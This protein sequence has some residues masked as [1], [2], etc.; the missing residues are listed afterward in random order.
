MALQKSYMTVPKAQLIRENVLKAARK[1]GIQGD[2]G[3]SKIDVIEA[4]LCL[5][6]IDSPEAAEAR[7]SLVVYKEELT[8]AKQQIAGYKTGSSKLKNQVAALK[9]ELALQKEQT[10]EFRQKAERY[11]A[12]IEQEANE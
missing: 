10:E 8:K 11:H 3:Y 6:T 4:W 1:W 9:E 2:V 7:E 12:I 5:E